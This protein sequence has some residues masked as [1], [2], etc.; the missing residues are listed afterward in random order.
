MTARYV[1]K[2]RDAREPAICSTLIRDAMAHQAQADDADLLHVSGNN[3]RA[4]DRSG[5]GGKYRR[6]PAQCGGKHFW[7]KSRVRVV[8][9]GRR[10]EEFYVNS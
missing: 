8:Q 6:G 3:R 10:M 7:L 1:Q 5:M 9:K 2:T 4:R